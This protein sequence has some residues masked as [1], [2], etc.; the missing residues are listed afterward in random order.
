MSCLPWSLWGV[1][2]K[3]ILIGCRNRSCS[4][5]RNIKLITGII[6]QIPQSDVIISWMEYEFGLTQTLDMFLSS[7][8]MIYTPPAFL[9]D[10]S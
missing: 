3:R 10:W 1:K 8:N 6:S 4:I 9:T 2:N 5:F 7:S